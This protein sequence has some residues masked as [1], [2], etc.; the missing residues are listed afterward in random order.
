MPEI[1]VPLPL[2]V[3]LQHEWESPSAASV[4]AEAN[5][6][7]VQL[8][9]R[10]VLI[11]RQWNFP[12][13]GQSNISKVRLRIVRVRPFTAAWGRY[14]PGRCSVGRLRY[15]PWG[16]VGDRRPCRSIYR[17]GQGKG[18]RGFRE[19]TVVGLGQVGQRCFGGGAGAQGLEHGSVLDVVFGGQSRMSVGACGFLRAAAGVLPTGDGST[20]TPSAHPP[21]RASRSGTPGPGAHRWLALRLILSREASTSTLFRGWL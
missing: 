2:C 21:A 15:S 10:V 12:T 6:I 16:S 13:G 19:S 7:N 3:Q 17:P 18:H 11:R 9:T 4:G 5:A 20:P 1:G 8:I 14:G